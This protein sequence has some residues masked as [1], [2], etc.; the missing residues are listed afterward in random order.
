MVGWLILI[1]AFVFWLVA[2][3]SAAFYPG[4]GYFA[5]PYAYQIIVMG[6]ALSTISA[7]LLNADVF[8]S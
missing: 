7:L 2:I 1:P 3:G 8:A 6:G 4:E 5:D